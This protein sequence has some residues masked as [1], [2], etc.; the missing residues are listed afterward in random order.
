[1]GNIS[2][3]PVEEN[4]QS[5]PSASFIGERFF[6]KKKKTTNLIR[7]LS[8]LPERIRNNQHVIGFIHPYSAQ[9]VKSEKETNFFLQFEY[10]AEEDFELI[11]YMKAQIEE[12]KILS[13]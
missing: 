13:K 4:F 7:E 3:H 5:L 8:G 1:M 11:I 12:N 6:K 2:I 9:I 10:S